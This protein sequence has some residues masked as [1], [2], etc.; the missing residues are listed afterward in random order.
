MS[1]L[2]SKE[3]AG[4]S[5]CRT[6]IGASDFGLDAYSYSLMPNDYK[7]AH[8]SIERDKKYVS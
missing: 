3:K 4:F 6:A 2:F 7:M 5:F 1:N 8:F